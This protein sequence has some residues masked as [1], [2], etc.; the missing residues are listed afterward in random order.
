MV[1]TLLDDRSDLEV[2]VAL[3]PGDP[4]AQEES[5]CIGVGATKEAAF[6]AARK[7]LEQATDDL[8]VLAND[9]GVTVPR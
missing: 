5:F 2:W 1:I 8:V 6:A 4:L 9:H 3:Q 7:T